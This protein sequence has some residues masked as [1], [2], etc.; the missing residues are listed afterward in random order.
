[1]T[2][3]E[4]EVMV[5]KVIVENYNKMITKYRNEKRFK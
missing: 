4:I 5:K 2:D 1:M 3:E